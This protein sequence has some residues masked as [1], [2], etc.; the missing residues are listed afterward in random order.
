MLRRTRNDFTPQL[1]VGREHAMEAP[2][3]SP[4][5]GIRC[6]R[7]RGTSAAS[8]CMN[9][10][11]AMTIWV[12]PSLNALFSSQH[13]IAG[14]VALV[15]PLADRWCDGDLSRRIRF[16]HLQVILSLSLTFCL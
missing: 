15:A 13:Y 14:A 7:G 1:R 11:G 12:V 10:S 3:L 9:S 6:K 2:A 5:K 8:R 16:I 4:S